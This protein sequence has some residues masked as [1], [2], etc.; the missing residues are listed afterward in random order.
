MTTM[1]TMMT[2]TT[3]Q[4]E[5]QEKREK[6]AAAPDPSIR[7]WVL[8]RFLKTR[9]V[10]LLVAL[11]ALAPFAWI[12]IGARVLVPRLGEAVARRIAAAGTLPPVAGSG[13]DGVGP[14]ARYAFHGPT[15]PLAPPP[16]LRSGATHKV[17]A[18][19]R[20]RALA[21]AV[22][23]GARAILISGESLLALAPERLRDVNG[24]TVLDARGR[25][26]GV[27]LYGVGALGVGLADGDVVTAIDGRSTP[28][29]DDATSA[30]LTAWSSGKRS[31]CATIVRGDETIAVTVEIPGV[32]LN[33]VKVRPA[34][35]STNP[36]P[37]G[38]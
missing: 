20:D 13:L 2:T 5:K 10:H 25:P 17:S 33:G 15:G 35:R 1:T 11:L 3:T 8:A 24:T 31:A 12:A 30:G 32:E 28:T 37:G 7:S 26:S 18:A 16:Q 9:P 21:N 19:S 23:Q 36:R 14:V 34:A 27:S 29:A 4:R 6:R 38:M 22:Q